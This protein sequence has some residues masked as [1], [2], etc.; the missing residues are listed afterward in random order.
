M[1]HLI[2]RREPLTYGYT[3]T[4]LSVD[5]VQHLEKKSREDR[6]QA[7]DT[8]ARKEDV[9][10]ILLWLLLLLPV[11]TLFLPSVW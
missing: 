3:E 5:L 6:V 7:G 11:S 2:Y 9:K 4:G 10:L 8:R 1:L